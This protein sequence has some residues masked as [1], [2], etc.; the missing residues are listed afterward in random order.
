MIETYEIIIENLRA[1]IRQLQK[2]N[3]HLRHLVESNIQFI[4]CL[5]QGLHPLSLGDEEKLCLLVD[6]IYEHFT[7]RLKKKFPFLSRNSI[8]LCCLIKLHFSIV[9]ISKLTLVKRSSVSR[10]KSR[11]KRAFGLSGINFSTD[12]T[13]DDWLVKF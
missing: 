12:E 5:K 13:L 3:R 9:E 8:I 10:Q 7:L 1:D 11:I 4:I 2:E 6:N